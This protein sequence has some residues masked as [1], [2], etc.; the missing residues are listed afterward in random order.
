MMLSGQWSR[1]KGN[2]FVSIGLRVEELSRVE[3]QRLGQSAHR[4][5]FRAAASYVGT[6]GNRG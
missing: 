2:G 6:R 1:W 4:P 3:A 5:R